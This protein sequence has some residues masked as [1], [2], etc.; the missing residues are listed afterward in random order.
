MF[1]HFR[2]LRR[3][4]RRPP[5]RRPPPAIGRRP[6][7]PPEVIRALRQAHAAMESSRFTEAAEIFRRLADE[8]AERDMPVRAADLN[9]Q[10]ARALWAAGQT[11]AAVERVLLAIRLLI[12]GH[13]AERVPRVLEK[14]TAVLRQKG[15]SAEADRLEREGTQIIEAAGLSWEHLRRQGAAGSAAVRRGTL[16]AHCSGCGAPLL[17]DEVEWH[18]DDTAECPYCGAIIKTS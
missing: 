3:P 17:P 5:G 8:A 4:L 15:Y 16:P 10:T 13:R 9:L 2:R 12:Q 18:A 11:A 1:R 14:T 6:P 7:P